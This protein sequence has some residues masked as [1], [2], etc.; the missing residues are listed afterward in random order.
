[1][2]ALAYPAGLRALAMFMVSSG[3]CIVQ[4]GT[5]SLAFG[6]TWPD[7]Q[8]VMCKRAGYWPVRMLARDG[9]HTV[10]AE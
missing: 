1:M 8:S 6:R 4:S 3:R 7:I 9:E 5:R 10:Q 2:L